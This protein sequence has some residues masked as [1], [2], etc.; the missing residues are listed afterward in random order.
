MKKAKARLLWLGH[1]QD[2]IAETLLMRLARGSGTGGLAAPRPAQELSDGRLHL[3]PMLSL[4]KAEI[5][6]A[7]KQAGAVW[8]ED[9]SNASGDHFRNRIRARVLPAWTLSLHSP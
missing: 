6:T 9:A 8:R 7:L 1:Q 3:R 4:K 5:T 2:D